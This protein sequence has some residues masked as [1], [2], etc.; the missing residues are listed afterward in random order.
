MADAISLLVY[1]THNNDY[2]YNDKSEILKVLTI[3][4]GH[5]A[6]SLHAPLINRR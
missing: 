2:S 4:L 5:L 1:G 3:A 6:T